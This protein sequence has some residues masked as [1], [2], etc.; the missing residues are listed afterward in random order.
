[1]SGIPADIITRG[2]QVLIKSGIV[3]NSNYSSKL[4]SF[5]SNFGIN[6]FVYL[7]LSLPITFKARLTVYSN[8]VSKA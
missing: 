4:N 6:V 2:I 5:C 3:S 7:C 8:A 1:M